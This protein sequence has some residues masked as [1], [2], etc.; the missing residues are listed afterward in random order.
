MEFLRSNDSEIVPRERYPY[1]CVV[2]HIFV[3]TANFSVE[4]LAASLVERV[5]ENRW[6][7]EKK[8]RH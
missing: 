5:Q 4:D 8:H 1:P 6:T 3:G 2:D 7:I